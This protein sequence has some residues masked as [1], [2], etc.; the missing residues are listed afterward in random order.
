[1]F[2]DLGIIEQ[3]IITKEITEEVNLAGYN[4]SDAVY[5]QRLMDILKNANSVTKLDLSANCLS[6]DCIEKLAQG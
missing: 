5:I 1:M 4:I 3:L 6:P 2:Q